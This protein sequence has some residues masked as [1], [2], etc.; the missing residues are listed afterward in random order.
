[1]IT[2]CEWRKREEYKRRRRSQSWGAQCVMAGSKWKQLKKDRSFLLFLLLA[3]I[4][5]SIALPSFAPKPMRETFANAVAVPASETAKPRQLQAVSY[6]FPS[7][8]PRV[9]HTY[10][11]SEL[12]RGRML[13]T[14]PNHPLPKDFPPPNTYRI[15]SIGKGRVP[16]T[17][18]QLKCGKETI[19]ALIPLFDALRK[20]G[21]TGLCVA[22]GTQSV[23]EQQMNREE[24][25]RLLMRTQPVEEAVQE[26]LAQF[27]PPGC[28][29]LLQEY[30]VEIRPRAQED[31]AQWQTLMQ[32]SWRY[33]FV[34]SG[35]E[36]RQQYRFR[37]VGN[38]HATAMTYLALDFRS[39]LEWLHEAGVVV[40]H[41][42][43]RPKYIILCQPMQNDRIAFSLPAGASYEASLD[44]L[45]YAIVACTLA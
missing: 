1:M 31:A 40:V 24:H 37:W 4:V 38:A 28:G 5:V 45:G 11:R 34:Q 27:D 12:L 13:Y 2:E 43:G 26:T 3:S 44:H 35:T 36:G 19:E 42:G 23:A 33:G 29:E 14:D 18:L 20:N 15:A 16:V 9:T 8:I 41:E 39:Y 10:T 32:L 25:L 22:Q 21:A 7:D 6:L 30:T 17:H